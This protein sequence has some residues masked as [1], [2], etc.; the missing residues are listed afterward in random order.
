M[1]IKIVIL[2][3][4]LSIVG[5]TAFATSGKLKYEKVKTIE[6]VFDISPDDIL[7]ISNK[8]GGI[9]IETW[10]RQEVQFVIEIIVQAKNLDDADKVLKLIEIDFDQS[11]NKLS[12]TTNIESSNNWN[13]GGNT[14]YEINYEVLMPQNVFLNV[15]NKY[16]NTNICSIERD[17]NAFIKYGNVDIDNQIRNVNLDLKYGNGVVNSASG[18]KGDIKYSNFNVIDARD[19]NMDTKY[20]VIIIESADNINVETGYDQYKIGKT[21]S[22]TNSGKYDD[23]KIKDAGRV[24]ITSKYTELDIDRLFTSLIIEQRYGDIKV[25]YVDKDVEEISVNAEYTDVFIDTDESGYDLDLQGTYIDSE[26]NR[27]FETIEVEDDGKNMILKG[28]LKDGKIKIRVN[29]EYGDIEID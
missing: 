17:I 2:T 1:N 16:G 4:I 8:Y 18:L 13:W 25:A 27:L 3:L 24:N 7:E 15:S 20:S 26:L 23:I 11:S 9:N 29:L 10:D 22:F 6:K 19:I 5:Y 21:G 28:K 12:A 14:K